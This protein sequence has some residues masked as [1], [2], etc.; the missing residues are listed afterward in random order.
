MDA[1]LYWCVFLLSLFTDHVYGTQTTKANEDILTGAELK[2][3]EESVRTRGAAT[4][5]PKLVPSLPKATIQ[6][7]IHVYVESVPAS[8]IIW[9]GSNTFLECRFHPPEANVTWKWCGSPNCNTGCDVAAINNKNIREDH[10]DGLSKLSFFPAETS[11]TGMY[12]C[13]V[14]AEHVQRQSCGTY[15]WVRK[16]RPGNFLNMSETVKNKI[17]TAEGIF[18]LI[19][20]IG[21]GLFLLYRKRWENERLLQD[22][23]AALE[24]ENLYEGLNLDGCSMYEDISRGLQATYQDIGN[25]KIIDLQLE[26]P[27]KP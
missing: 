5:S 2:S 10:K 4:S 25:V 3:S 15:L 27:E 11:D 12:Y 26:K 9:E 16:I 20:A 24:E 8:H 21:P 14:S 7:R 1:T 19:S 13:F 18:L 23:K 6:S 17:I 22:K